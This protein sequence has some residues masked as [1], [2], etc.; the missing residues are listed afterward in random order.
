[1][2]SYIEALQYIDSFINY[3]KKEDFSYNKRSFNL[4][5]M[6]YLLNLLGN[7]HRN[8]RAIHI[9]GTKGKGSTA[10]ITASILT[11]SGLKVGLYT[12]PHLITPRERIRIGE[13]LISEE[14]FT[15]FLSKIRFK[16][17]NSF[18]WMPFTFFEIYTALAF[19][20]FFYQKVDL[21]VLETG[22]GGR[23]DATNVV[24]PLVAIITQISFDHTKELG[25]DLTSIARE[26]G[27]IIKKGVTVI[28]SPQERIVVKVLEQIA[29]EKKAQLYKVGE[30]I[31]FK[32][33]ESDFWTQSF[34]LQTTKRAYSN[35]SLSLAGT[36]QLI[37]AAT[38]IGAI[39]L[40]EDKGIF[41]SPEAV[42]KGL[43][44]VKWPGRIQILSTKPFFILD[45]A[46]NGAS[47]QALAN[48]IKEN[49]LK[50][51]IIL[52]LSVL[53]NKDI[54]S[55]VRILCP[56]ADTI[57][58]S[59]V[60]NPR[61][62]EPEEIKGVI[63]KFCRGKKIFIEKEV[64]NAVI[65]AQELACSEGLICATGSVY[66]AGEIMECYQKRPEIISSVA[67]SI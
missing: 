21:A 34:S 3:E 27:G 51:R 14:E 37:N 32:K 59:R 66:L 25:E 50:E 22:L 53:K 24:C 61:T 8:L 15:Y 2:W 36:H 49:F 42:R 63:Q 44:R 56:L 17:E 23:L 41:L 18:Q 30:N 33:I 38:A 4:K 10:A 16:L 29:K 57:I 11:A 26:K 28:T 40:L 6:E 35:L 62:L 12:S 13:R 47:A 19:L 52:I 43:K 7:P 65:Y 55:I 67:V 39:D 46:H 31:Q 9:A 5:R 58:L 60:N 48:Y 20:Y 45:C 64:K 1:M 54:E